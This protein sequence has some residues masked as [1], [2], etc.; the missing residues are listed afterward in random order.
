MGGEH[1]G[2]ESKTKAVGRSREG[3]QKEKERV[4]Q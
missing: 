2:E 1:R 3:E 4:V